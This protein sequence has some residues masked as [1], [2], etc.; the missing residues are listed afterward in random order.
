[1]H[2]LTDTQ[3]IQRFI[4]DRSE[5]AFRVLA[6]RHGGMVYSACC[7]VLG[8]PADAEDA[9]QAVFL[10]FAKKAETL[11]NYEAVAGWLFKT[12]HL[13]CMNHIQATKRRNKHE[14]KAADMRQAQLDQKECS[15]EEIKLEL[16][17]ALAGLP[18]KYRDVLVPAY[19]EEQPHEQISRGLGIPVGT[20]KSRLSRGMNL[21]RKHLAGRGK[22]VTGTVLGSLLIEHT[23]GAAPAPVIAKLAAAAIAGL[24]GTV[25]AAGTAT[26][27][28]PAGLM[29]MK[30]VMKMMFWTKIKIAAA[31]IAAV[32]VIGVSA[33]V[34]VNQ[35]RGQDIPSAGSVSAK[36][37]G[38]NRIKEE[39][40]WGKPVNGM[41]L[42]LGVDRYETVMRNDGKGPVHVATLTLT[43]KNVSRHNIKLDTYLMSPG[44][45]TILTKGPHSR[46]TAT[47]IFYG[48]RKPP[49][50]AKDY[51]EIK[52]EES[53]EYR[54]R[55]SNMM[56]ELCKPGQ[57]RIKA[58]YKNPEATNNTFAKGSWTG[59]V[60]SNEITITVRKSPA[61]ADEQKG[62]V[63]NGLLLTLKMS[64]NRYTVGEIWNGSL[65]LEAAGEKKVVYDRLDGAVI[66]HLERVKGGKPNRT[67]RIG[68]GHRPRKTTEHFTT[69]GRENGPD[70]IDLKVFGTGGIYGLFGPVLYIHTNRGIWGWNI[71]AGT[72]RIWFTCSKKEDDGAEY[73]IRGRVWTGEIKSNTVTIRVVS[74]DPDTR[75]VE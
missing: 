3:L 33:H 71:P 45:V 34:A 67:R 10:I 42:T 38:E 61:A 40:P 27:I 19:L 56:Y 53:W 14:R 29:L 39:M 51:V 8:N 63:E 17:S 20:V 75:T 16:D 7:R 37:Q 4:H 66:P 25:L 30:G 59:E 24:S 47:P 43:F 54:S 1:M 69:L 28:S 18:R 48:G 26:G 41:Q 60:T 32:S 58:S 74:A 31:V 12:A 36:R 52:P 72:Y 70:S 11:I 15:W 50:R 73:G 46:N 49:P 22:A 13:V 65:L 2:S 5:E 57:Y 44:H 23:A 68:A 55:W 35:V 21:L 64:K 62:S 6:E 9:A